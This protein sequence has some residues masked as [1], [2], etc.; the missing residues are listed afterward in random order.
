[1]Q[2]EQLTAV[3]FTR[4]AAETKGVGIIPIGV[5]EVHS[6]HLPLGTDMLSSHTIACR[7]AEQE[8]AVV[9]PPFPFSI[10]SESMHIPG[11][12]ALRLEVILPLLEN[13]C[14]EL[15]RNGLKKIILFSG[16]GGNRYLL[17]LFVQMLTTRHKE[18]VV[19][20]AALPGFPEGREL[21]EAE[22]VGHAC[23]VETS[24]MLYTHPELV[25]M[26]QVPPNTVLNR[27]RNQALQENGLYTQMDWHAMYPAMYV[28]NAGKA[29]AEKG[30]AFVEHEIQMLVNA[31]RA[32]K[33]DKITPALNEEYL[34]K[35]D[36]PELPEEWF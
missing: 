14:D 31:I 23:E 20:Y 1:M 28:G 17:P 22:E 35:V 9:F 8:A 12:V 4:A 32:V 26:D 25:Q 7:A 13:L 18:Y 5:L 27:K 24:M 15:A 21:I 33:E 36:H 34:R 6:S 19:Y 30:K 11:A 2:W 10:N 16:H 29:S 3:D